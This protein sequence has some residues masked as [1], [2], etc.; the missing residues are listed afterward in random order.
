MAYGSHFTT[1][2][3]PGVQRV[4]AWK[5]ALGLLSLRSNNFGQHAGFHGSAQSIVSPLG[6]SFARI[7]SGPQ[8]FFGLGDNSPNGA[9]VTLLLA[10]KAHLETETA[11]TDLAPGDI[12]YGR[13]HGSFR[14]SFTQE[15]QQCFIV[16]PRSVL[17]ARLVSGFEAGPGFIRG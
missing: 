9:W 13:L 12:A 4:D 11:E 6:I 2:A 5:E 3:Y 15:F 8:E 1:A 7:A 17:D 14:I 16:I 10:G